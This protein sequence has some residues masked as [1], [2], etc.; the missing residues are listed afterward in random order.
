M[1]TREHVER[2]VAHWLDAAGTL[3]PGN[4]PGRQRGLEVGVVF[5]LM[6]LWSC[7][8]AERSG[9]LTAGPGGA[10]FSELQ[11]YFYGVVA[12]GVK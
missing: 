7:N 1:A 9:L 11:C 5:V 10:L 3:P 12:W 2:E 8:D 4:G 6:M